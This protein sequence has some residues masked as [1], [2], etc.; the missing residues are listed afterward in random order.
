MVG[1]VWR[2]KMIFVTFGAMDLDLSIFMY[3]FQIMQQLNKILW[4][5]F[6]WIK[7]MRLRLAVLT[8]VMW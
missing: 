2:Q 4:A 1:I 3:P 8:H 5:W 6:C 7:H